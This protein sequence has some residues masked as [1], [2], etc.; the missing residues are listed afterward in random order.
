MLLG[1]IPLTTPEE[2]SRAWSRVRSSVLAP[3]G[4]AAST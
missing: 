1:I 2:R 4:R 3:F